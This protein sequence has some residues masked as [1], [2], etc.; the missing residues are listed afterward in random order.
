MIDS[1]CVYIGVGAALRNAR[2]ASVA[3]DLIGKNFV[4]PDVRAKVTGRAKYPEDF[5]VEGMVLRGF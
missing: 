5:R 3:Y 4:P 1:P 2:R